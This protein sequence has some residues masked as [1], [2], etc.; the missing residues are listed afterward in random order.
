MVPLVGDSALQDRTVAWLLEPGNPSARYLT[1]TRLLG[2]R[3]DAPE[4][5]T[6]REAIPH[7]EPARDILRAQY[8]Q[9]Y[10]MHPGIGYSPRYRAT[11]WQ[12]LILAQLGMGRCPSLDRSIEH[13]F[14]ENQRQDGAFRASKEQGDTPIWLNGSLLWALETLGYG[15]L[16]RVADA[17][18]WL[19]REVET[20]GLGRAGSA[21]AVKVLWAVDAVPPARRR[22]EMRGLERTA[23]QWVLNYL[24]DAAAEDSA[25]RR[26]TFPLTEGADLLQWME[27]LVDAGYGEDPRLSGA[28]TWLASLRRPDG[29]WPLE[30]V[31]GKLWADFGE[32]G[33]PNK[34]ITIR[35]LA[36]GG[37]P[38][39]TDAGGVDALG[40][41]AG[42][43]RGVDD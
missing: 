2:R 13:L 31:P 5:R 16:S 33:Q 35:A 4:V 22:G 11:V 1:L 28:W 24:P 29:A 18:S 38:F 37:Q 25:G 43:G 32:P 42:R 10:W 19:G 21:G 30:R 23:S 17:W 39:L 15:G 41:G 14:E 20:Q 36:A 40:E 9:G 27:V 8:P 26:L 12:I 3:K 6:S 34:W 7:V